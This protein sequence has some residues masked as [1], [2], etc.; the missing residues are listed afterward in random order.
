[1]GDSKELF[2]YWHDQV[3][4][5]N[6][7]LISNPSH[8]P[9][10]TLRHDCTNYDVLRHRQDVKQ[11]EESDRSRVIAV[12]KYECTAQVLQ[13]RAGI[14]KDRVTEIQQVH[15]ETEKQYSTLMR[16]IKALQNQLF[17]RE[18]EIKKL[19]SRISTLEIENESLRIEVEKAKAHSEVLQELEVLQKKYKKI[20]TRKKELAKNN[21]SLGGRVAHTKRFRRERDEARELVKELRSQ[22]DAAHQENQLLQKENE[23]LRGKLDAA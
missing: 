9:T 4:L 11:L 8:V 5:N 21:Q 1:M 6:L 15:A 10:Q 13:R 12:I 2:D 3:K 23:A 18:K 17:G 16:L 22:L 20:E 14:L 7:D 19:Q